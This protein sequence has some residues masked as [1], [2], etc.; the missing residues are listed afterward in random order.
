MD[1]FRRFEN[2]IKKIESLI[3]SNDKFNKLEIRK[4]SVVNNRNLQ[5]KNLKKRHVKSINRVAEPLAESSEN[6]VGTNQE[7]A[8]YT[9]DVTAITPLYLNAIARLDKTV[10]VSITEPTDK[11]D[12][13][14]GQKMIFRA[15]IKQSQLAMLRHR[16]KA[17][18]KFQREHCMV[19][20]ALQ[21]S[22][23]MIQIDLLKTQM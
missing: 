19:Q 11:T 14:L 15:L 23:K 17:T 6:R 21:T 13:E 12:L 9:T 20:K 16:L 22:A 18:L 2:K 8:I 7:P 5:R 1:T 10:P 4:R 3:K